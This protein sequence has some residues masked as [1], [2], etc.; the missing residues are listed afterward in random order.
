MKTILKIF[1]I[2]IL[3]FSCQTK[4]ENT[5]EQNLVENIQSDSIIKADSIEQYKRVENKLEILVLPPYDEIAN[6][7]I[8]PNIRNIIEGELSK[9]KE[10]NVIKFPFKKLMNT[11]Y[12]NIFDKRY[13][14]PILKIIDPDIIIMSKLD[15]LKQTGQMD[16]DIW[17]LKIRVFNTST[18]IQ[19]DSEI[20]IDSLT[21]PEIKNILTINQKRLI[22]EIKSTVANSKS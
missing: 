17:N 15:F 7:G 4:Q 5:T 6:R 10:L 1:I 3:I 20:K 22:K 9:S 11:S 18:D 13:C 2:S 14:K 19:I 16:S 21:A 8:S 12:Q